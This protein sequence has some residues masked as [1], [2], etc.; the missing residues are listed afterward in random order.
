MEL[1]QATGVTAGVTDEQVKSQLI[2]T[3]KLGLAAEEAAKF[4]EFSTLTGQ[5]T[6]DINKEILGEVANL[7]NA[8]GIRIDRREE[9][10]EVSKISGQ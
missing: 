9:V 2:L 1:A 8:T 4:A 5:A 6:E 10:K 3:G 7:E